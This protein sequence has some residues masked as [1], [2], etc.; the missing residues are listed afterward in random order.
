MTTYGYECKLDGY[1]ERDFKIATQPSSI[2]CPVCKDPATRSYS[3]PAISFK[4]SG[5]YVN[6]NRQNKGK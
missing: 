3:V 4:G 5:F 1:F 6:D 2:E